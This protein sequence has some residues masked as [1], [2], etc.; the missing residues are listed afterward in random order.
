M[1]GHQAAA[2]AFC[3]QCG[4]VGRGT[5]FCG[6]PELVDTRADGE[7]DSLVGQMYEGGVT[8]NSTG[9]H[10]HRPADGSWCSDLLGTPNPR[11]RPAH[12]WVCT[13]LYLPY[14]S[15]QVLDTAHK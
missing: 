11:M 15:A 14:R 9:I 6:I 12:K 2:I 1:I 3:E 13:L 8:R 5:W 10:S 4:R 7:L